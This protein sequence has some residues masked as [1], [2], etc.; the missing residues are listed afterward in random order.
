MQNVLGKKDPG[1]DKWAGRGSGNS[2]I[3]ER[4]GNQSCSRKLP[5][6]F[7]IKVKI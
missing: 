7:V 2:N 5:P 4:Q 1:M 6:L 3:F